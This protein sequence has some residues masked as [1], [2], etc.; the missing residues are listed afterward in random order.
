M[1][2]HFVVC[3]YVSLSRFVCYT[4]MWVRVCFV[5]SLFFIHYYFFVVI[6]LIIANKCIYLSL[7]FHIWIW[8]G[9][10]SSSEYLSLSLFLSVSLKSFALFSIVIVSI[11]TFLLKISCFLIYFQKEWR[12][13]HSPTDPPKELEKPFFF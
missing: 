9:S 1:L 8:S 4:L 11:S 6:L 12:K 13:S 3:V 2:F 10:T 7:V 5:L